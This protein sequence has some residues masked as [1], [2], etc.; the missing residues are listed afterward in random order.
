MTSCC[1]R[2]A[3]APNGKDVVDCKKPV[4]YEKDE[5]EY[6]RRDSKCQKK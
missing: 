5:N 3:V 2:R 4:A 1:V 6:V